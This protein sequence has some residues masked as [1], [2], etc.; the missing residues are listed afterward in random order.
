MATFRYS[1]KNPAFKSNYSLCFNISL[2]RHKRISCKR[3]FR[4]LHFCLPPATKSFIQ[5]QPD[6]LNGTK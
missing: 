4:M 3:R 5:M 2:F 6:W 1:I